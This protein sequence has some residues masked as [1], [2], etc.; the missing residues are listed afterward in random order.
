MNGESDSGGRTTTLGKIIVVK[1]TFLVISLGGITVIWNLPR[2]ISDIS[3]LLGIAWIF[4]TSRI[5]KWFFI[6]IGWTTKEREGS[7]FK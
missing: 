6:R 3:I 7:I 2:P 1:I 4:F 5:L